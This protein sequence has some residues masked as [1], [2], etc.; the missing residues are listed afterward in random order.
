[1]SKTKVYPGERMRSPVTLEMIYN[2]VKALNE[3]LRLIEDLIEDV[4]IRTLRQVELN[5]KEIEEIRHSIREMKEG[6]YVTIE[7][8]KRA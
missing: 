8:L 5:E 4:L 1:M 3:R 2:E 7:E 6:N